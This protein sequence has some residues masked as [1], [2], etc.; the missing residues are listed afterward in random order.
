VWCGLLNQE[1]VIAEYQ[2]SDLSVAMCY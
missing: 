1:R 2:I